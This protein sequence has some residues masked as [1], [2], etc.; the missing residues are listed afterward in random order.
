MKGR[1]IRAQKTRSKR[2]SCEGQGETG[3]DTGGETD[4]DSDHTSFRLKRLTMWSFMLYTGGGD[5]LRYSVHIQP[6]LGIQ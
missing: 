4:S 3:D 6:V 5:K 2:I 1:L